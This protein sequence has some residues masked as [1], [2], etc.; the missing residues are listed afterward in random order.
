MAHLLSTIELRWL[1]AA[2][3]CLGLI[4]LAV[5]YRIAHSLRRRAAP[6][7]VKALQERKR[8]DD[9]QVRDAGA[10]SSDDEPTPAQRG[11]YAHS[12]ATWLVP[13]GGI[14]LC[15]FIA[16]F[17]HFVPSLP[18]LVVNNSATLTLKAPYPFTFQGKTF[19]TGEILVEKLQPVSSWH[20]ELL[21]SANQQRRFPAMSVVAGYMALFAVFGFL[22]IYQLKILIPKDERRRRA[23][24]LVFLLTVL[25]VLSAK[26][27]SFYSL[28]SLYYLPLACAGMLVTIF[29]NRRIVPLAVLIAILY[30]AVITQFHFRLFLV[31]L[32]GG[33]TSGHLVRQAKKR[34]HL[35][36][37]SLL[38]GIVQCVT[39]AAYS[40][41]ALQP[42]N[43][44]EMWAAF[45]GG[46][47]SGLLALLLLPILEYLF[48][49]TSPFQLMELADLNTPILREFF[50]KAPGTYQHSIS[51]AN[52]AEI[53]ATEIHADGLLARV[54]AYYH[55]I[56]KIF[57][58]G[59]F[60]ENQ[61][62]ENPHD[63]MGPVASSSMVRSHVLYGERLARKLG[64]P[65]AVV[66]MINE[67]HGTATIDF[68]HSKSLRQES[69][70]QSPRVFKYPG[71]KPQSK[72]AAILMIVDSAEAAFRV[73]SDPS[74]EKVREVVEKI[75]LRKFAQGQF[76]HTGLSVGEL[77][78]LM[79]TLTGVLVRSGHK[80][81]AY[82]A[83]IG[84]SDQ[85]PAPSDGAVGPR[86]GPGDPVVPFP[87]KR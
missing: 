12:A 61:R 56:G 46:I 13:L 53:L 50:L 71:P 15:T 76:D 42:W 75:V 63:Q 4:V 11:F 22:L 48:D 87:R 68:F 1:I 72:E 20:S 10:G 21:Q 25:L 77:K 73:L 81:I 54:G 83:D 3:V 55:D 34:S 69:T 59:Y 65:Q 62:G 14:L 32:A 17:P 57:N 49:L 24:A 64:L 35:L 85:P 29:V 51:V 80:R 9:E 31:L 33:L 30:L 82:P 19:Q 47:A 5:S 27:A 74:E 7:V 40:G 26:L 8:R 39:L 18:W 67:H 28:F 70:M 36:L 60:I 41:L 66:D 78:T 43:A 16:L 58:P 86:E 79:D 6:R 84:I 37:A 2:A 52:L 38:V 23:V 44:S 45:L